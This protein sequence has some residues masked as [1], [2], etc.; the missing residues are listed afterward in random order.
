M[1][2]ADKII[3]LRK[4]NGWSQEE[5]AEQL[6]VTRQSV[7]K[8]EGAQ[9]I[10]DLEKILQ[11]SK[12]FGV[13]T[14][15]L[16][17]EEVEIEEYAV[18]S[19]METDTIHR[20]S[21]EEANRFLT[22]KQETA[23]PIA[24]ATFLCILSPIC[25][26]LFGAGSEVGRFSITENM[27][28]GIGMCILLLLIAIAVS[29]FICCGMK[30]KEYE[31]MEKEA[32][33]TEYGV[34]GMVKERKKQYH[35]TYTKYN[36]IGTCICICSVIPIFGG[37]IFSEEDF[38]VACMVCILLIFVAIGVPFFIIAGIKQASFDKLLQEGDYSIEKKRKSSLTEAIETVYWLLVTACFLGYSF[39]TNNWK[40]AAFIWPIAGVLFAAVVVISNALQD[41]KK[42]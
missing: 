40:Y 15:Y 8:W 13:T 38:F 24:L 39:Y 30:T 16:V 10:P 18:D 2:L 7:S 23:R 3:L 28:A 36:V 41:K 20:V 31:Y 22:V 9:S 19:D 33:D 34:T 42:K 25:L 21:M 4:K 12:I 35:S 26:I 17:K 37:L 6:N 5:L 1:I 27:A 14:D 11:L 32:I 29:I